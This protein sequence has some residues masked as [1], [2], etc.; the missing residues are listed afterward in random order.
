[1]AVFVYLASMAQIVSH[2]Q[3]DIRELQ[4]FLPFLLDR[5]VS[6]H[7]TQDVS[8]HGAGGI[9]VSSVVYSLLIVN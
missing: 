7:G 3:D 4:V 2:F 6:Q 9:T 5:L 1:M 8:C